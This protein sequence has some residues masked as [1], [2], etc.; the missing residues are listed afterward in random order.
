MPFLQNSIAHIKTRKRV[1]LGRCKKN[2][3]LRH[4]LVFPKEALPQILNGVDGLLRGDMLDVYRL[5][6]AEKRRM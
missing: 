5:G 4:K 3:G 1:G 6:E 2:S